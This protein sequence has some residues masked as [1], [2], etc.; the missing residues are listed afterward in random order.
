MITK[1]IVSF[2]KGIPMAF[3]EHPLV[4]VIL[5]VLLIVLYVFASK[6]AF[7]KFREDAGKKA[8]GALWWVLVGLYM[9]LNLSR[10][11][12]I[13]MLLFASEVAELDPMFLNN[14]FF[15]EMI[16]ISLIVIFY[17]GWKLKK[18]NEEVPAKETSPKG[19][20][21]IDR[22]AEEEEM[23]EL[24]D[25]MG[26]IIK[27]VVLIV[28][29]ILFLI[30]NLEN[31]LRGFGFT[32]FKKNLGEWLFNFYCAASAEFILG[33]FVTIVGT[34]FSIIL[35]SQSAQFEQA[36]KENEDKVEAFMDERENKKNKKNK[37]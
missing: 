1:F 37:K 34:L 24:Q 10:Y 20:R 22:S 18:M 35:G 13:F 30:T 28:L 14:G 4:A 8:K 16:F 32:V 21:S 23:Q 29:N 12:A 26:K 2:I 25:T 9:V 27:G 15:V 19:T 31:T 17:Y 3:R 5:S 33:V 11:V 7:K 6:T 36:Y